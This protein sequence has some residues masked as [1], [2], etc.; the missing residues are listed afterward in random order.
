MAIE[1]VSIYALESIG[2]IH[3]LSFQ[4]SVDLLGYGRFLR[5]GPSVSRLEKEAPDNLI[6]I[7]TVD[8]GIRRLQ[9]FPTPCVGGPA[10]GKLFPLLID[11]N[12][13]WAS[14]LTNMTVAELATRP[15][16]YSIG[17]IRSEPTSP[18]VGHLSLYVLEELRTSPSPFARHKEFQLKFHV[19]LDAK[20]LLNFQKPREEQD[21]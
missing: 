20:S 8:S 9:V 18:Y 19:S 3:R 21:Q 16:E 1:R 7:K 6:E 4:G 2:G 14:G 13:L 5:L 11:P 17:S 15:E 10:N 12:I